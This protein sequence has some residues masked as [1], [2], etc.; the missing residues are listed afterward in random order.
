LGEKS[1]WVEPMSP[2]LGANLPS[3]VKA[4]YE[5][6]NALRTF[7]IQASAISLACGI[8]V[9][10]QRRKSALI[11]LWFF[12]ISGVTMSF[13]AILQKLSGTDKILW[14]VKVLNENPWGTFAY[15]NQGAAFLILVLLI[16]GLLYFFYERRA[17]IKLKQGGPHQLLFFLIL[18][19]F[20]SLWLALSRGGII[21]GLALG[22]CFLFLAFIAYL[23]GDRNG[24]S[25]LILT[26]FLSIT[27]VAGILFF[28][29]SDTK[30]IRKRITDSLETISNIGSYDRVLSTKATWEMAQ[31]QLI[32][33]WGAGS[34]RYIFPIYQKNYNHLWYL[35]YNDKR[36]WYFRKFYSYAH[37]DW[38][39]FLADYGIVGCA[40]LGGIFMCICISGIKL[41]A[42]TKSVGFLM[43]SGILLIFLHNF[44]DFIFSSPAYWVAFL[45]SIFLI[46]KLFELENKA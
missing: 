38:I 28:Q 10:I 26:I 31:D 35:K 42:F 39:Q 5:E 44:V 12:V 25:L 20:S 3:S 41:F 6:M 45:G 17:F 40:F 9:G 33:G 21:L 19:L 15:R 32:Y 4:D 43:F 27:T 22:I 36:G 13:V 34:F 1:W 29:L 2:P 7:V 8:L 18:L 14:V 11:I 30:E 24:K 23:R 37:N 46:S 16:S